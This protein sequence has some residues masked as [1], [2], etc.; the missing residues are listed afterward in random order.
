MDMEKVVNEKSKFTTFERD[1]SYVPFEIVDNYENHRINEKVF[2]QCVHILAESFSTYNP[3]HKYLGITY[4]EDLIFYSAITIRGMEDGLAFF[5]TKKG[6]NDIVFIRVSVDMFHFLREPISHLY[7]SNPKISKDS[8]LYKLAEL[9]GQLNGISVYS[10]KRYGEV[11]YLWCAAMNINYISEGVFNISEIFQYNFFVNNTTYTGAITYAYNLMT[12]LSSR[13]K[14]GEL[15]K[16]ID[17][18][19]FT[20]KDGSKPLKGITNWAEKELKIKGFKKA[21]LFKFNLPN[22]KLKA[23][24]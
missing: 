24:F 1:E 4:E 6:G 15:V 16:C 14:G 3:I 8:G 10:P 23:Y 12:E 9:T 2:Q 11:A 17:F 7:F 22:R 18:D 13:Q 21:Y 19:E 5:M 20:I